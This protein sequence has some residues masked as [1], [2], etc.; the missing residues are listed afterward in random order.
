MNSKVSIVIPVFNAEKIVLHTLNAYYTFFSKNQP[1]FEII[2]V[3][4]NC[5]D[6]SL[7]IV[8]EF[9]KSRKE[10]SVMNF[11]YYTGKGGAVIEGFKK[12]KGEIIGFVDQDNSVVPK[13][14]LKMIN[15]FENGFDAVIASRAV[16]DSVLLKAQ[17]M[18]RQILGKTFNVIVNLFF[19]L[20][21]NDSVCGAKIFSKKAVDL[22]LKEK[23]VK[24]FEFDVQL[25]WIARK[26]GLN[27]KEKGISW[28]NYE[29]S[30]MGFTDPFKMF[31]S[32]LKLR[33]GSI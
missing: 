14:F 15:E 22:F 19:D 30:T 25:L 5:A 8:S 9:A 1:N 11:D 6:D 32:V 26:N 21:V 24:G 33:F 7:K 23:I 31:I 18:Y 3:V 27:I 13:E 20:K 4:N 28:S 29:A 2:A 17:P 10:M 16:K 12:A